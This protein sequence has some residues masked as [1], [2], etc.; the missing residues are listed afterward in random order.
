MLFGPSEAAATAAGVVKL[1]EV[2]K[3]LA[4]VQ[5]ELAREWKQRQSKETAWKDAQ[6]VA[7]KA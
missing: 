5:V 6:K 4:Q 7:Q 2:Q 3:E 1:E